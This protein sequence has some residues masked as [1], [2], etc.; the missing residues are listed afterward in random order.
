MLRIVDIRH[1]KTSFVCNNIDKETE[2]NRPITWVFSAFLTYEFFF[3]GLE[4]FIAQELKRL[5]FW[6]IGHFSKLAYQSRL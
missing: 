3:V 5:F 2:V 6:E 4:N 1:G